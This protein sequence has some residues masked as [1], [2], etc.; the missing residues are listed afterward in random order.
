[1]QY[2]LSPPCLEIRSIVWK[3]QGVFRGVGKLCN[4]VEFRPMPIG[5]LYFEITLGEKDKLLLLHLE[6]NFA[7]DFR[8]VLYIIFFTKYE[9]SIAKMLVV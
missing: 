5:G 2:F 7:I 3:L 1:M 8:Y 9:K 4:S 6:E